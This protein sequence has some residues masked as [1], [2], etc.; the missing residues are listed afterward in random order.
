MIRSTVCC[1]KQVWY[2]LSFSFSL[3][4]FL[5]VSLSVVCV[6]FFSSSLSLILSRFL[7]LSV[8]RSRARTLSLSPSLPPS[9]SCAPW[10][11]SALSADASEVHVT[12]TDSDRFSSLRHSGMACA[13]ALSCSLY[14]L[15]FSFSLSRFL[16][17]SLS[18]VCVSLFSSSL[19]LILSPSL[20]VTLQLLAVSSRFIVYWE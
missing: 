3:S 14:A 6:S 19:S 4:R 15:S 7:S 5:T 13:H 12:F 8:A 16:S 10:W 20:S 18:V 9:L 1:D 2:A 17:V 11:V